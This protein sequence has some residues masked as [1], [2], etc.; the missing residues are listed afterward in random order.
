M[1]NHIPQP[2]K[3]KNYLKNEY[4]RL[5]ISQKTSSFSQKGNLLN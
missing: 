5:D 3:F 2:L 4:V 1:R